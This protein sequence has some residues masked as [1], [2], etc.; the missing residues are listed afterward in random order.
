MLISFV[1]WSF[2][3]WLSTL[4]AWRYLGGTLYTRKEGGSRSAGG[5]PGL[6]SQGAVPFSA[7]VLVCLCPSVPANDF[8]TASDII[9][10]AAV[11]E[12]LY[13]QATAA[14]FAECLSKVCS[15]NILFL[16]Q[17][18]G[19]EVVEPGERGR[20]RERLLIWVSRNLSASDTSWYFPECT[21]GSWIESG[22]AG[23]S[24]GTVL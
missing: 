1:Y 8:R 18:V 4:A 2:V 7:T 12:D 14:L 6:A 19:R 23:T 20:E 11:C 22:E 17:A 15:Q 10:T 9:R 3:Y 24:A 5:D 13:F 16:P 21:T